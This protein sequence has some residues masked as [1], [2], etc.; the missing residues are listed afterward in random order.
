MARACGSY[1]QCHRF[2]SSRRYHRLVRRRQRLTSHPPQQKDGP[3]VKWL[4]HGPFTAVTWVRVPYGSPLR[5]SVRGCRING[6]LAQLVRAPAS[7]AGGHWFESSSLHHEK[8]LG[9][10]VFPRFFSFLMEFS[11]SACDGHFAVLC[12]PMLPCFRSQAVLSCTPFVPWEP[13]K[14]LRFTVMSSDNIGSICCSCALT[15]SALRL[16]V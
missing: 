10:L 6:G 9:N 8:N 12:F 2:E 4:R 1:P 13:Y 11:M 16:G 15:A 14:Y 5:Q 7:H 3:L